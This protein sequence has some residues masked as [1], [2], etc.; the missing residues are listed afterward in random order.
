MFRRWLELRHDDEMTDPV[1]ARIEEL[2]KLVAEQNQPEEDPLPPA[3]QNSD[4]QP[5]NELPEEDDGNALAITGWTA[6]GVGAAGTA[7]GIVLQGLAAKHASD[8]GST[9]DPVRWKNSR[10]KLDTFQ[11]SAVA[12]FVVG[13]TSLGTGI[14][15]L[16][17][18]RRRDNS[19][20]KTKAALVPVPGGVVLKGSF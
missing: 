3:I 2:E 18:D 8:T 15:L 1:L 14:I 5:V 6:L 9:H 12:M 13:G 17:V 11:K 19:S 16:I 10:N 7:I 4:D 20:A